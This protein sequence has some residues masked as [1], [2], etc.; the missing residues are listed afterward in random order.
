MSARTLSRCN[1]F[2]RAR[3]KNSA[4]VL[5][6]QSL[7]LS[8]SL[9][10]AC[11]FPL[12][13]PCFRLRRVL[14]RLSCSLLLAQRLFAPISLVS[15]RLRFPLS[16]AP[17]SSPPLYSSSRCAIARDIFSLSRSV[18]SR[19]SPH[20]LSFSPVFRF[21][22]RVH[23]QFPSFP[24]VLDNLTSLLV[25]FPSPCIITP[26]SS[27]FFSIF[28]CIL[29][30]FSFSSTS[31]RSVVHSPPLPP[32]PLVSLDSL[33]CALPR[34]SAA[35]SYRAWA[36]C[37]LVV[38]VAAFDR[39]RPNSH[40][41][42]YGKIRAWPRLLNGSAPVSFIFV[43]R[44]RRDLAADFSPTVVL[45]IFFRVLNKHVNR[46]ARNRRVFDVNDT[47]RRG[48]SKS[49]SFFS[50]SFDNDSRSL[51]RYLSRRQ[52]PLQGDS[53]KCL[54][55]IQSMCPKESKD[56]FDTCSDTS[57]EQLH[58]FESGEDN[59]RFRVSITERMF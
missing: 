51:I 24:F 8:F 2:V 20:S 46:A 16:T 27:F 3:N 31:L 30:H 5:Q 7:F 10:L 53:K 25:L 1:A 17:L 22:R 55:L 36:P 4:C 48:N 6:S 9:C 42:I 11:R 33:T 38:V 43:F 45:Y 57:L 41:P 23:S 19:T 40:V 47:T 32:P 35:V 26:S 56:K 18:P 58:S 39:P 28:A 52:Y 50:V 49:I 59:D 29:L 14:C 12:S 15:I 44:F 21:A 37:R 54:K 34:F 13:L